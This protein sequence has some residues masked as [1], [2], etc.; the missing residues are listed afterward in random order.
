M[1]RALSR[2]VQTPRARWVFAIVAFL[3][4]PD[5][6]VS[7]SLT[8]ATLTGDV[9][10]PDGAVLFDALIT[11]RDGTGGFERVASTTRGG[12]FALPFVP[13][14]TYELLIERL[15][16]RPKLLRDVS[17]R[18]GAIVD[19]AI[20]LAPVGAG[21]GGANTEAYARPLAGLV[22]GLVERVSA[23]AG[24]P[25]TR[26]DVLE[27]GRRASTFDLDGSGEGL[28]PSMTGV[29]W[30][31]VQVFTARHPAYPRADDWRSVP[32]L[33]IG[34]AD[35]V[36][37]GL[38][39]EWGGVTGPFVSATST[40]GTG[41]LQAR[42]STDFSSD[43]LSDSKYFDTGALPGT[44]VRATALLTGPLIRDS[45]EFVIGVDAQRLEQ[46]HAPLW[47]TNVESAALLATAQDSFATD[48]S[49]YI[50]PGLLTTQRTTAFGRF[51]WRANRNHTVSFRGEANKLEQESVEAGTTGSD[52]TALVSLHSVLGRD[53]W[54]ELRASFASSS[55]EFDDLGAATTRFVD[56]GLAAGGVPS[57][58][59]DLRR[60]TIQLGDAVHVARGPH[61]LKVGAEVTL[62]SYDHT[63]ADEM[64][65]TYV[66]A[67]ANELAAL[68]GVFRQSVGAP[69]VATFTTPRI[70]AFAQDRWAAAPGVELLAGVRLESLRLPR[71]EIR[72]HDSL[73]VTTGLD[74]AR[75]PAALTQ[76]A[77]R[78]GLKW[79]VGDAGAWVVR[80]GAGWY[81]GDVEPG[82]L[83][84]LI[85]QDGG[86]RGR[87]GV[88]SVGTWPAAPDSTAAPVLGPRFT[89][90]GPSF[91]APR[92]SR[93][94]LALS[95]ALGREG[96]IHV[97]VTYRHTDFLPRRADLNRL[98]SPAGTDQY[99][100]PLYGTLEQQGSALVAQDNRRFTAFDRIWAINPDGA[101]DYRA[102]SVTLERP[103][104]FA[105][106][107]YSRT[108]DNWLGARG[109]QSA[110]QL[111]PF[112]DSLSAEDWTDD[113]SD[114]D[115]PHRL[116]VGF[117]LRLPGPFA[118]VLSA[119][120][121][122]QSGAPFT[123]G[124]RP[125]VDANGDGADSNDPAYVDDAIS[126]IPALLDAQDCLRPQVGTFATRNSCREPAQERLDLRLVLEPLRIRGTPVK[127]V[128]DGLNVVEADAGVRDHALYLVDRNGTL[129]ANPSTG[130]VTVPLVANAGFGQVLARRSP[131]RA[132][133]IGLRVGS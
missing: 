69:P 43:A 48:L 57:W 24:L 86:V 7:Q 111:N 70:A 65:G 6:A 58:G 93:A 99:G 13:P 20:V 41:S 51:D 5:F 88:G 81:Y 31:G 2:R 109:G 29:F 106:Y 96:A 15:G 100:R 26:R 16:Y 78:V 72:P 49:A 112:P 14:G 46:P 27:L 94:T 71:D 61:R 64:A 124:F 36:S 80:A 34:A 132:F 60:T 92:T 47:P 17:V 127:L 97:G 128:I 59:A 133:R 12:R 113:R 121:R 130:V 23:S 44:S 11:A 32:L 98:V 22:P 56:L 119:L 122:R 123:P 129:T 63:H 52:Y 90:L 102:V 62:S 115:V 126:G 37:N 55:R 91:E 118:P 95:R 79:D 85:T 117:E 125:G 9:R 38:D 42:I 103:G 3:A 84:D 74:N 21:D 108:T 110:G 67:G 105:S 66:F 75:I 33:G 82:I 8:S 114:F 83:A 35:V 120:Y 89:L 76:V 104:F 73:L 19:I 30:D 131:G 87:L 101:S 39:V 107:T 10:G 1:T 18:A 45:A 77:P 68:T 40:H 53:V 25:D 54:Q 50:A 116:V 28:P 4:I